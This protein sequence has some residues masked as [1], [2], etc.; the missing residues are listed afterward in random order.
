MARVCPLVV[1]QRYWHGFV[2]RTLLDIC[3]PRWICRRDRAVSR[4]LVALNDLSERYDG[5][6]W[7][8][9]PAILCTLPIS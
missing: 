9:E 6:I 5:Q 3:A 7:D 1:H 8:F 2:E 4:L